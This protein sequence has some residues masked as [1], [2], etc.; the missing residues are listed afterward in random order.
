MELLLTP[1]SVHLGN[2]EEDKRVVSI[3]LA[4]IFDAMGSMDDEPEQ[5]FLQREMEE[6]VCRSL[7]EGPLNFLIGHAFSSKRWDVQTDEGD[8]KRLHIV[9][10]VPAPDS[11]EDGAKSEKAKSVGSSYRPALR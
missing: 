9:E 8:L 1:D 11:S 6:F 2:S 5:S 7:L 10:K 3:S 4:D